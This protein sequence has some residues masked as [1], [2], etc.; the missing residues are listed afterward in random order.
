MSEA[1]DLSPGLL[2]QRRNL[3]LTSS[4][5]LFLS[6]AQAEI[7]SF[8]VLGISATFGRPEAVVVSLTL[9]TVYFFYRYW[10]YLV[11]EPGSGFKGEFYRRLNQY[12][13]PKIEELRDRKFPKG[14][15]LEIYEELGVRKQGWGW[16]MMVGSANIGGG[17]HQSSDLEVPFRKV[18]SESIKAFCLS[19]I[20]RSY[21]TDYVFPI[22]LAVI[23]LFVAFSE[24]WF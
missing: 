14:K 4:T 6:Y 9:M 23:A 11:Q 13:R 1:H 22:L 3:T 12:S 17:A 8:Q 19:I 2:R 10:L 5:L 16:V 7:S 18:W 24:S 20:T 15:G 21:F